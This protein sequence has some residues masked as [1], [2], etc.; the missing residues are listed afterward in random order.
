MAFRIPLNLPHAGRLAV[1]LQYFARGS[2]HEE[3]LG[4]AVDKLI[5]LLLPFTDRDE[6][7]PSGESAGIV[8]DAA[9]LLRVIVGEIERLKAGHDR[10]GQCVRNLFECLELGEEGAAQSLRAGENP[11]SV[12]RPAK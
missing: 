8:G 5:L 9:G 2:L 10:L 1:R 12:L 3:A 7:P 6:N 11:G 4:A